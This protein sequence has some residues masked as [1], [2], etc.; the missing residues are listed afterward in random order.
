MLL[1]QFHP[2]CLVSVIPTTLVVLPQLHLSLSVVFPS[3]YL[4][5]NNS[6][7]TL[8]WKHIGCFNTS[9]VASVTILIATETT[10]RGL[11]CFHSL[12]STAICFSAFCRSQHGPHDVYFSFP[13]LVCQQLCLQN[14]ISQ[15]VDKTTHFITS[16]ACIPLLHNNMITPAAHHTHLCYASFICD[17]RGNIL[18]ILV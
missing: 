11:K 7:C 12:Y 3:Q 15:T 16:V 5:I 13:M 18:H 14:Y 17:S 1:L 2:S 10:T 6:G 8:H 9:V 4:L